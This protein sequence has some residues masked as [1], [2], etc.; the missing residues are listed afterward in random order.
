MVSS[1][2]STSRTCPAC[3]AQNSDFSIFCAECGAGLSGGAWQSDDQTQAFQPTATSTSP[4]WNSYSENTH[5]G[6]P[7]AVPT[8]TD[9][10]P[11]VGPS[12][13]PYTHDDSVV[14]NS[15]SN[16]RQPEDLGARGFVLG[17]LAWIII[18]A[19]FG[20]FLWVYVLSG[21][22]K[23]DIRDLTPGM[24]AILIWI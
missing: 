15:W 11:Y 5:S 2:G 16:V 8:D 18:L 10:T 13:P 9:E 4:R 19:V 21:A 20:L 23:D 17:A 3:G 22:L 7:S 12:A 1:R 14:V 24:S 6:A